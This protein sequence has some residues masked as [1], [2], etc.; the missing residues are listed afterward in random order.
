MPVTADMD[1]ILRPHIILARPGESLFSTWLRGMDSAPHR[2]C[3][4]IVIR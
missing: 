3:G 4:P 2:H 1:D